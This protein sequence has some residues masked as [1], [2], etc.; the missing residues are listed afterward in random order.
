[1]RPIL[2]SQKAQALIKEEEWKQKVEQERQQ[3]EAVRQVLEA[4]Q[5]ECT[6]K[7]RLIYTE[8]A[9]LRSEKM[10]LEEKQREIETMTAIYLKEQR[11]LE[12]KHRSISRLRDEAGIFNLMES[13][14]FISLLSEGKSTS[15]EST[16][17]KYCTQKEH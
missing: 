16:R 12:E 5:R 2:A 3:L 8:E 15:S 7:K 13:L 4:D 17:F 6:F 9:Q 11:D 1:M 10:K 14:L